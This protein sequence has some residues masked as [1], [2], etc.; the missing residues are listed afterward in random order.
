MAGHISEEGGMAEAEELTIS[1]TG[2]T[3]GGT[4]ILNVLN[5]NKLVK[6]ECLLHNHRKERHYLR[7]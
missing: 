3:S 5:Q 2:A 7:K 1:A 6:E 4:N